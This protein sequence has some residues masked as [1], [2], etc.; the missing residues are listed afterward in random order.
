M[1][2]GAIVDVN[3]R[4]C[5][6]FGYSRDEFRRI[7]IGT[8]GTGHKPY[9]Q[10]DAMALIRRVAAGEDLRV[11]WHG[12]SKTGALR[13]HEVFLKRVTI[14]GLQFLDEPTLA[15]MFVMPPDA[16]PLPVEINRL[17][18]QVLVRYYDDEWRKWS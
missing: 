16:G 8:M 15:T 17:D 3:S 14:G 2:T 12:K 13:W 11:E 18:N 9:T 10:D 5:E 4:A 6:T 1:Q 7:D